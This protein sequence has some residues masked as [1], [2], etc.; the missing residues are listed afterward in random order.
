MP[1][2]VFQS[3]TL[4]CLVALPLS[5]L[6]GCQDSPASTGS[7]SSGPL[8]NA[9]SS[10]DPEAKAKAEALKA[11]RGMWNAY[12]EAGETA[13]HKSAKL[14]L[15]TTGNART[16]IVGTLYGYRDEGVVTKGR[17]KMS[18]KITS[19]NLSRE[20]PTAEVSDCADSTNWTKHERASGER[21]NDPAGRRKITATVVLTKDAW[22]VTD[23]DAEEIGSC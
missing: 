20:P 7:P 17:L 8:P 5:G 2:R 12:A 23:F 19:I 21:I 4:T 15:Y 16:R 14:I 22:K 10:K 6:A 9:S 3:L 13:D 11:Y 1:W 18:P